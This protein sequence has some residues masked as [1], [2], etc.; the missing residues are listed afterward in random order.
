M[1]QTNFDFILLPLCDMH[2][3]AVT[4]FLVYV[5]LICL[6]ALIFFIGCVNSAIHSL[7]PLEF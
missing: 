2:M 3:Y 7:H 5:V 4:S 1:Q 6:V